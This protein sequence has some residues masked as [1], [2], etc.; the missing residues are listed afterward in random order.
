L[1]KI[2]AISKIVLMEEPKNAADALG[3]ND[4]ALQEYIKAH[5]EA[6]ALKEVLTVEEEPAPLEASLVEATSTTAVE[7]PLA[8]YGA[9]PPQAAKADPAKAQ[10]FRYVTIIIGI[11]MVLLVLFALFKLLLI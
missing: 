11:V 9:P 7:N 2:F 1:R 8:E 4:P 3:L 10:I 6:S 5:P